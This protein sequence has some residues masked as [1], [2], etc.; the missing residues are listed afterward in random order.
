MCNVSTFHTGE[1]KTPQ[2]DDTVFDIISED[3]VSGV[4]DNS[5]YTTALSET[6]HL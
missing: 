5:L 1:L 4:H 2:P 6:G 3:E